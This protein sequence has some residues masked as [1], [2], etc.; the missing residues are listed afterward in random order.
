M[1]QTWFEHLQC[2]SDQR[3]SPLW[4]PVSIGL[5]LVNQLESVQRRFTKRLP[6]FN[7]FSNDERCTW[8]EINRLEVEFRSLHADLILGYKIVHGYVS[9]SPDSFFT[10]VRDHRTRGHSLN[11]FVP[12][13]RVIVGSIFFAVCVINVWN[14]LPDEVISTNQLSRFKTHIKQIN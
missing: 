6:G 12:D 3:C 13:A 2:T 5:Q 14:S 11:L 8:L 1:S 4:S 9:L 7:S 10:V